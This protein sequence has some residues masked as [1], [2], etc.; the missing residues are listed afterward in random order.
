MMVVAYVLSPDTP[1]TAF[2]NAIMAAGLTHEVTAACSR[3]DLLQCS[4]T[5][6]A[7]TDTPSIAARGKKWSHL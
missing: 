4:C 3:G 2:L 6:N 5:R 1:E 7:L